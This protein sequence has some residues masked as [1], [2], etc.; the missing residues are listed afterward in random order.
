MSQAEKGEEVMNG[1]KRV[2]LVDDDADFVDLNKNILENNGYEVIVAYNGDECRE[3]VKSSRPDIIVLDIMMRT[4]ADGILTVQGLQRDEASK[5]I[6]IIVVT[7]VMALLK[8]SNGAPPYH[9]GPDDALVDVDMFM[10]KPV[11]PEQLLEEV[12]RRLRG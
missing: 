9:I 4:P 6:P 2:L 10:A 11:A 7:S 3:K 12:N 8:P 1:K 5:G